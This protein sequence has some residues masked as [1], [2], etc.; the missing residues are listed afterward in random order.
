ML[1]TNPHSPAWMETDIIYDGV[2]QRPLL[3]S[4]TRFDSTSQRCP[5]FLV[6]WG[7]Q[8]VDSLQ[9]VI[10]ENPVSFETSTRAAG[11]KG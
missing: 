1:K 4:E 3:A 7:R 6:S 2:S 5:V 11:L 8:G 9:Q 10:I